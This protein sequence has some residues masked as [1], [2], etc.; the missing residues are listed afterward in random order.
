W[1]Q[2]PL[3]SQTNQLLLIADSEFSH[4]VGAMCFH[5]SRANEQAAG[6][7]RAAKS[8]RCQMQDLALARRERVVRIE[9]CVLRLAEIGGYRVFGDRRG[10]IE[11]GGVKNVEWLGLNFCPFFFLNV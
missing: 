6:N 3:H 7:L 1:L 4:K 5:G 8:L 11:A 9:G 10:G 2:S